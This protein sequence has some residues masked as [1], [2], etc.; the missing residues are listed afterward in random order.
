[1]AYLNFVYGGAISYFAARSESRTNW[2]YV[3]VI[4]NQGK[5]LGTEL[6]LHK[7]ARKVLEPSVR[8]GII[9]SVWKKN[10]SLY[11]I[12]VNADV[13]S[14][15]WTLDLKLYLGE[16]QARWASAVFDARMLRLNG[17]RLFDDV[18]PLDGVVYK[19]DIT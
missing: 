10:N 15:P 7:D 12:A 1:M 18:A 5:W 14:K 2:D 8:D 6:F 3:S 17:T 19:I 4:N 9:F 11:V 16:R 13:V